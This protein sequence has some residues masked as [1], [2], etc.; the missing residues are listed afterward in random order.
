MKMSDFADLPVIDCHVHLPAPTDA[1]AQDVAG[2]EAFVSAVIERGRLSQV[3]LS[4]NAFG[5]YLKAKYAGRFYIGG[6]VPWSRAGVDTP[7]WQALL[8]LL[9]A[10]GCDGIGEMGSKPAEKTSFRPLA[11]AFYAD[12][13]RYCESNGVPVLCHVAD[14]EEF[15][16]EATAPQWA[17][18]RGWVYPDDRFP[19]KE[20]LHADL[21]SVLT[22]HPDISMVLAHFYFLSADLER[23]ADFLDRHPKVSFDLTPGIELLYNMSRKRDEWREFFITYQDRIL[24]GTDIGGWLGDVQQAVDRIW[25]VRNFLE[26]DEEFFTPPTA[27][28]LMTRYAEPFCGL[29]LPEDVLRKIY[30]TNFQRMFGQEPRAIDLRS[31][32][33]YCEK[34]GQPAVAGLMRDL[35]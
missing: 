28:A 17:K 26:S 16:D 24:F 18:D 23:A 29:A 21:E 25:I 9:T 6:E 34:D 10:S 27:D 3:Y 14:P 8:G 32:L 15:W 12:Y 4:S 1:S 31:A 35:P 13:W 22:A 19:E 20:E 2:L 5:L 30:A 7:D 33:D 11:D